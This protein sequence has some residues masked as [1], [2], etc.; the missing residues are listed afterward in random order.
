MVVLAVKINAAT[1]S[2]ALRADGIGME[3]LGLDNSR[4]EGI[5][6]YAS[7]DILTAQALSVNPRL[8]LACS[9]ELIVF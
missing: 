3:E 8:M 1:I 5:R 4:G 7:A 6:P 2:K 9:P